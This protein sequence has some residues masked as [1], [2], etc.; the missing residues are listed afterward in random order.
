MPVDLSSFESTMKKKSDKFRNTSAANTPGT[1]VVATNPAK[2]QSNPFSQNRADNIVQ[3]QKTSTKLPQAESP[4]QYFGT[5][6]KSGNVQMISQRGEAAL[7][8]AQQR[9]MEKQREMQQA[10]WDKAFASTQQG[11][12]GASGWNPVGNFKVPGFSGSQ[13]SNAQKIINIG[14]QRGLSQQQITIGLMTAL[15]ESG[16]ENVNYGDRDSVGLFQQRTSQ[17]WGTIQQIMNP[18]YSINKFYDALVNSGSGQTPWQ[19]AQ[20]VQRSAFADGSN[21][22]AQYDRAQAIM[23]AVQNQR[24]ETSGPTA[25]A[26]W[27]QRNEGKYHD[28]DKA[29]GAQCVDLYAYYTTGFAG[30]NPI[31]VTGAT[32]IWNN[33]DNSV[34]RRVGANNKTRMG[35][36]AI[37]GRSMG[38]GYG[39]VGIVVGDNGNG[40]L[41]L[42]QANATRLGPAGNTVISNISKSAL[43]G[44]LRPTRLMK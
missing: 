41:R 33:F 30:G 13:I 8:N 18:T 3:Q 29:Y 5:G 25:A 27:I 10:Q 9:A 4:V 7:Q 24:R 11:F 16:L 34:Y 39:H 2:E 44:Y 1:S 37:F 21:Y 12:N 6:D 28:Y 35:D 31:P 38:G 42:L 40:T 43:M 15:A 23:N 32:E 19:I 26:G 17:G 36:V 14:R 20:S 22:R